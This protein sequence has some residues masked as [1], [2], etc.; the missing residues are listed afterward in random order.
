M[1]NSVQARLCDI[2]QYKIPES[3]LAAKDDLIY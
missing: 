3:M 1:R 2:I